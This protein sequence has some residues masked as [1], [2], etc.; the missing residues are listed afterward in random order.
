M[1]TIV[2]CPPKPADLF[3]M[4]DPPSSV[5]EKIQRTKDKAAWR[6]TTYYTALALVRGQHIALPLGPSYV[7]ISLPVPDRRSRDPHNLEPTCKPITDG[8]VLAGFWP[9]DN[10]EWVSMLPVS[11]HV[12]GRT[13]GTP[14]YWIT[15]TPREAP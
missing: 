6:D 12:H 8:L 13:S 9:D 4:N 14:T 10:P 2:I 7:Q 1:N 15:I 3:N 11:T 5:R